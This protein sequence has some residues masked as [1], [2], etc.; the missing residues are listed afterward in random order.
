MYDAPITEVM[1]AAHRMMPK[2]RTPTSPRAAWKAEAGGLSTARVTPPATTPSTARNSSVRI[3]PVTRMPVT[4]P[5]VMSRTC[6]GP[7]MP[8]STSRWAPA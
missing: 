3:T 7:V 6:S 1:L 8:E 5:R 4:E 2:T